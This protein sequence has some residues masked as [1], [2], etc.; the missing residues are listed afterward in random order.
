MFILGEVWKAFV[1]SLRKTDRFLNKSEN[2]FKLTCHTNPP[3]GRT[4]ILQTL[5]NNLQI[6]WKFNS[7]GAFK[8]LYT[9]DN[10][11]VLIYYFSLFLLSPIGYLDSTQ[12][13]IDWKRKWVSSINFFQWFLNAKN[14]ELFTL[15]SDFTLNFKCFE[16]CLRWLC[17]ISCSFRGLKMT[18]WLFSGKINFE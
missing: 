16:M 3:T 1:L 4:L 13:F 10:V 11:Y 8:S 12:V 15:P 17:R 14:R 6:S 7:R 5:K 18:I 9:Q 2:K